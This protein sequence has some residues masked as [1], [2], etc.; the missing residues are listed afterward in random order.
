MCK[1]RFSIFFVFGFLF[2]LSFSFAQTKLSTSEINTVEKLLREKHKLESNYELKSTYKL[3]I[4]SGSLEEAEK[5][6][7][8]F[9]ADHLDMHSKIVYQTPYYKI[10][11]GSYR[12]RIQAD[13]AFD[14]VK[15]E[16]PNAL[17]IRPGK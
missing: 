1:N 9:T 8:E 17:I 12:N 15:S 5:T 14:K 4:Y 7:E 6:Q 16:Y 11:V 13:R 10:W 2:C 3:Q